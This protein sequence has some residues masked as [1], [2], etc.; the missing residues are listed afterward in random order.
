MPLKI[1]ILSTRGI[2]NHYGGFEQLAEY[3]SI[4]LVEKGHEVIVY[5]SRLHPFKKEKWNEVSLVHC[6]DPEDKIGSAGQF[7]YDFNCLIDARNRN[8]DVLLILG[9]TSISV[10]KAIFPSAPVIIFNMDG[11]EW[12][13]C[14]YSNSVKRFLLYAEK[15][16]I[17]AGDYFIA[18]SIAIQSY[19]TQKYGLLPGYIAYGAEIREDQDENILAQYG[20]KR[21]EYYIQVARMEPENNIEMVLEGFNASFASEKMIVLGDISNKFAR[22]LVSKFGTDH[23]I[24]FLGAIYDKKI[25]HSLCHYSKIYF[26]GHSVGGTNPSLLEAMASKTLIAAHK[27]EFNQAVLQDNAFYFSNAEELK[28]IIQKEICPFQKLAKLENNLKRIRQDFSWDK[29][30]DQY[31]NFILSAYKQRKLERNLNYKGQPC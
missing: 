25:K 11:M 4:G 3:L 6:Y 21:N 30:V 2:P 19:L 18:D 7:I 8:F 14:K 12:I 17:N 5:N 13:R 1:G 23:R 26:H 16:A 15:L 28:S 27:N 10:W 29:I 22:R 20:I 31:E 24:M 9:Y